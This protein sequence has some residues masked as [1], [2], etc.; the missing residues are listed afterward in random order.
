M[1]TKAIVI[2]RLT[3]EYRSTRRE[4]IEIHADST[5]H[6]FYKWYHYTGKIKKT[7]ASTL[8]RNFSGSPVPASAGLVYVESLV[9][10]SWKAQQD[11]VIKATIKIYKKRLYKK[12][13]TCGPDQLG[14]G[15]PVDLLHNIPH[16]K[17]FS[18]ARKV[19]AGELARVEYRRNRNPYTVGWKSKPLSQ[20]AA[21]DPQ[22]ITPA[23][24]E[25]KVEESS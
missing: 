15:L 4:A 7:L 16:D 2:A 18:N 8:N 17:D 6:A 20:A 9:R 22:I 25:S 23:K 19:T 21:P 13:L 1:K 10:K 3:I 14:K 11:P 24:S 5:F 12:F